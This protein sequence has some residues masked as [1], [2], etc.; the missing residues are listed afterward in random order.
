MLILRVVHCSRSIHPGSREA[1]RLRLWFRLRVKMSQW[2]APGKK[3]H[4]T[5][6]FKQ[7]CHVA[8]LLFSE[9]RGS[10]SG[11]QQIVP[12]PA[13][14]APKFQPSPADRT[15]LHQL[16]DGSRPQSLNFDRHSLLYGCVS[17]A[18]IRFIPFAAL[19]HLS[20]GQTEIHFL[21]MRMSLEA[22]ACRRTQIFDT[23]TCAPL[24]G[25]FEP[26]LSFS[27]DIF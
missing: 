23:L 13:A 11:F 3:C 21:T 6:T 15:D 22:D 27:C 1:S 19:L 26:P 16:T 25:Y 14:P 10:G 4:G 2:L 24:G 7:S 18:D 5:V 9:P 8:W 20:W 17:R 12:A